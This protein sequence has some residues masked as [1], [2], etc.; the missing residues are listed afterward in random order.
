MGQSY[1]NPT[2]GIDDGTYTEETPLREF[3]D[4]NKGNHVINKY[5]DKDWKLSSEYYI[6]D[7]DKKFGD[8]VDKDGK[9]TIDAN[10]INPDCWWLWDDDE[11]N[12]VNNNT[13]NTVDSSTINLPSPPTPLPQ[14]DNQQV[15]LTFQL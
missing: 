5:Y 11:K 14:R 4:L 12:M 10:K 15:L 3:L 9:I 1:P 2:N 13:T 7:L 6:P 8:L